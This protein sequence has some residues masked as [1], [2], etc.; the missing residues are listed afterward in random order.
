ML[1]PGRQNWIR[2][3]TCSSESRSSSCGSVYPSIRR[4]GDSFLQN[5]H[6]FL[7]LRIS[8]QLCSANWDRAR[9]R[10]RRSCASVCSGRRGRCRT[11]SVTET[12]RRWSTRRRC[13]ACCSPWA[14][15][16]RRARWGLRR[17]P[18][19][20]HSWLGA[21]VVCA[22]EAFGP[23]DVCLC[24]CTVCSFRFFSFILLTRLQ[25]YIVHQSV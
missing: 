2:H 19:E 1:D 22:W 10:S 14:P 20:R 12:G 21:F 9:A 4:G 6:S 15:G 5:L 23:R 16:S 11:S 8:V 13:R 18:D 7:R 24:P 25:F 3:G 17:R